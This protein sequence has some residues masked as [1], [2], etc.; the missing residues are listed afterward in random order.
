MD[1]V[2]RTWNSSCIGLTDYKGFLPCA[3]LKVAGSE[4]FVG[5]SFAEANC[6][7]VARV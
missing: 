7:Q 1:L 5:F 3:G 4:A 2:A 6:A